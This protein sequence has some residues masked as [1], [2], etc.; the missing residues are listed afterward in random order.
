MTGLPFAIQ[1][2]AADRTHF[3]VLPLS[4]AI[5]SSPQTTADR[6]FRLGLIPRAG[7]IRDAVWTPPRS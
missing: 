3:G 4:D 1:K 7:R 2:V 5:L 6:F